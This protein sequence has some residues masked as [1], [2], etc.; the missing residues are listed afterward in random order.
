MFGFFPLEKIPIFIWGL[1][2]AM[3]GGFLAF[4]EDLLTK[5]Q[6][7]DVGMAAVGVAAFV[8]DVRRRYRREKE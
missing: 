1:I 7:V 4:Q 3:L 5:G 8:Y 6:V 2:L